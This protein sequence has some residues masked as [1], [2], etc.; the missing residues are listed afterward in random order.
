MTLTVLPSGI[1]GD[2]QN[3]VVF[4]LTCYLFRI[5]INNNGDIQLQSLMEPWQGNYDVNW[6][7]GDTDKKADQDMNMPSEVYK[8]PCPS[9][10]EL[11]LHQTE[12]KN[13]GM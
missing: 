3:Q 4:L 12:S 9:L 6:W 11:K 2:K 10:S 5:E 7:P 1:F 8:R 13:K